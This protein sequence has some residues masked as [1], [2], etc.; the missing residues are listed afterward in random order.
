[1]SCLRRGRSKGASAARAGI[2][3][4]EAMGEP[5]MDQTVLPGATVGQGNVLV[6]TAITAMMADF[7][8]R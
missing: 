5:L 8:H 4:I 3:Q 1:M 6:V 7:H 2:Y